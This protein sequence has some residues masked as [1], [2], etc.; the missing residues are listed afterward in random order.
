MSLLK[1]RELAFYLVKMAVVN[2]IIY[3]N[4]C[5]MKL[6]QYHC[7]SCYRVSGVN[8]EEI[9]KYILHKVKSTTF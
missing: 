8:E 7:D 6:V 1:V 2:N 3:S 5:T 9:K 4:Q